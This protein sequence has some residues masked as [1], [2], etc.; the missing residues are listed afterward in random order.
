M[1]GGVERVDV[2]V[3]GGEDSVETSSAAESRHSQMLRGEEVAYDAEMEPGIRLK[4]MSW[5]HMSGQ[6]TRGVAVCE[7]GGAETAGAGEL[8][9]IND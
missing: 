2:E 7:G 4:S 3:V 5:S 8:E 9:Y 6:M 1:L